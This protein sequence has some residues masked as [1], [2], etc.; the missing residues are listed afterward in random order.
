MAGHKNDSVASPLSS[1]IRIYLDSA[2]FVSGH[3]D[4]AKVTFFC[5]KVQEMVPLFYSLH[6]TVCGCFAFGN[7]IGLMC[8]KRVK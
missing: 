4:V 7:K 2:S 1:P 3:L 5:I 6:S 8:I